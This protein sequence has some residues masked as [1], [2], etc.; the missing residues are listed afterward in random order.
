MKDKPAIAIIQARMSSA[1]LPGKVLLPLAGKPVIHHIVERAQS[2]YN[3]GKVIVAT[4][5]EKSDDPLKEY[6]LDNHI[7]CY[8]GSLNNVLSRFVNILNKHNYTYCV[9]I[10]GD[11]PL[12]HPPFIDAQIEAL[13]QIDGDLIWTKKQSEVLE[14]QGVLSTKAIFKAYSESTDSDDLEHV[15]SKYFLSNAQG[16]NFVK[17]KIPEKYYN[18]HYRLT[19]DEKKDFEFLKY[20]YNQDWETQPISLNEILDWLEGLDSNQIKNRHVQHT[21]I[22]KQLNKKRKIFKPNII[23]SFSWGG[24]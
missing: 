7:E 20:I 9:R 1:R 13:Y 8:R 14:G 2:C 5:H 24:D 4:S 17:L 12:I 11:C 6:C 21:Q 22:N 15:G 23:G 19:L 18:Y 16:C 3:V 10:T